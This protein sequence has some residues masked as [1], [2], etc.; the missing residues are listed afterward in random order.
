MS[1]KEGPI[2]KQNQATNANNAASVKSSQHPNVAATDSSPYSTVD[3]PMTDVD[4]L[5]EDID[6]SRWDEDDARSAHLSRTV[7][8]ASG[9]AIRDTSRAVRRTTKMLYR[10]LQRSLPTIFDPDFAPAEGGDE[11]PFHLR[12]PG[13]ANRSARLKELVFVPGWEMHR[14]LEHGTEVF[15]RTLAPSD[16]EDLLEGFMRLSPE[17]RYQR[18]MTAMDTLPEAYLRYLTE[19][20][21]VHHFAVIAGTHDPAR[22]GDKGLGVARFIELP[23]VENEAELAITVLDEAQGMGLG[24]IFME[25]LIAAA[26]ER[27]F[28]ALRAEVLPD[29]AGMQRLAARF[30]GERISISDGVV[31]WRVPVPPPEEL[32]LRI[33]EA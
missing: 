9:K 33:F 3:I 27:G 20:D 21:Q 28:S 19:I 1:S 31:T 15:F 8:S 26:S 24:L 6:T 5:D 32:Q 10:S 17:S 25:I 22:L 16:R 23:D 7:V 2:E 13:L 4:P 12:N 18:F 29:N 11:L 30:G 14:V